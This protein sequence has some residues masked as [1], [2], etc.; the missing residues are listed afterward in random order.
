MVVQQ[1]HYH[2][3]REGDYFWGLPVVV[4]G[5]VVDEEVVYLWLIEEVNAMDFRL[6][7]E[8]LGEVLVCA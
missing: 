8:Q 4:L 6:V 1:Q 7:L 3:K 2:G 5:L